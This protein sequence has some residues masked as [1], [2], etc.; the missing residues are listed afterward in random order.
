MK[1]LLL[2]LVIGLM[3]CSEQELV[4]LS[5]AYDSSR[6]TKL[7]GSAYGISIIKIDDHEYITN[8]RGGVIHSESC[9]CKDLLDM[10]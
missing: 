1:K 3:S 6:I 10:R 4:T 9:P 5:G 2:I 7:E 8:F